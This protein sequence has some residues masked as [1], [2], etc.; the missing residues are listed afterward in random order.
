MRHAFTALAV[1]TLFALT[2]GCAGLSTGVGFY[3]APG[4]YPSP[5]GGPPGF[6]PYAYGYGPPIY[7]SPFYYPYSLG[8]VS[9]Y[10]LYPY[11]YGGHRLHHHHRG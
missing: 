9:P 11:R 1:G 10:P 7:S 5:Y 3:S 8:F 4:Y 6:S 2:V